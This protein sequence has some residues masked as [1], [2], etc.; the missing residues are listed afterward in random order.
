MT[1]VITTDTHHLLVDPAALPSI[2][3]QDCDLNCSLHGLG[4]C[5]KSP[6]LIRHESVGHTLTESMDVFPLACS[7]IDVTGSN[8]YNC[9]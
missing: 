5:T 4:L 1:I 3:I 2:M 9:Y 8:V 6:P 7:L